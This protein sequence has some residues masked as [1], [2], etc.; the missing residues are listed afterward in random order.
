MSSRKY[1]YEHTVN[2]IWASSNQPV[3]MSIYETDDNPEK[4]NAARKKYYWQD[5]GLREAVPLTKDIRLA[6][7]SGIY[8]IDV[9]VHGTKEPTDVSW[10]QKGV[11]TG[12]GRTID[13]L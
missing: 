11:L 8:F 10:Q 3:F 7:D 13:I 1:S 4:E 5:G 12:L 2:W 9:I 6:I